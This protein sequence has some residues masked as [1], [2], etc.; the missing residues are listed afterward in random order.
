MNPYPL[1]QQCRLIICP[2]KNEGFGRVPL[3][4]G[5]L[6]GDILLNLDTEEDDE[7][8][9]GCAGGIDITASK[10]YK[11]VPVTDDFKGFSI[12]DDNT[13]DSVKEIASQL[14]SHGVTTFLPSMHATSI[15]KEL[16]VLEQLKKMQN[17]SS[18]IS[19]FSE[20]D[21]TILYNFGLSTMNEKMSGIGL[22]CFE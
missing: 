15:E 7:I 11:E 18:F 4:A 12:M 22:V 2:A 10:K 21:D 17:T 6:K 13:A 20:Q 9:I 3:E 14:P 16:K 8:D 19:K 5:Y 1:I